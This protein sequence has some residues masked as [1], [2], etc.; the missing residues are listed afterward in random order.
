[1]LRRN[2]S[3]L[4]VRLVILT[5]LVGAIFLTSTDATRNKV[6]AGS[7]CQICDDAYAEC[8]AKCPGLGE[9]GHFTCILNCR[10][11]QKECAFFMCNCDPKSGCN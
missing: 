8:V 3:R 2:I 1:M 7:S 5:T 10:N 6:H 11:E 9:P 4:F